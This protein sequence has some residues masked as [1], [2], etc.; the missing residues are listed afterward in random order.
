MDQSYNLE[1]LN[2]DRAMGG[3]VWT[4]IAYTELSRTN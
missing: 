3:T 2:V 4:L 1:M